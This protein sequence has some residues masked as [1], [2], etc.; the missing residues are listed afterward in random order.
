MDT[1]AIVLCILGGLFGL[2]FIGGLFAGC[3]VYN[4]WQQ[5]LAGKANLEKAKEER[6]I[7]IEQAQAEL[8][9]SKIRAEAI[10]IMGRAAKEY[11]EY[12]HQEFIGAFAE[13]LNNGDIEK[14]IFVPTEANIPIVQVRNDTGGFE[15]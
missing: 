8:D 4:V 3:P 11:P 12:R 9:S 5:G 13:A 15:E 1:K 10:Q 14:V 7:L 2:M 6:K